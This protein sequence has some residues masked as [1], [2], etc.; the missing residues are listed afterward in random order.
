MFDSNITILFS[1]FDSDTAIP[2]MLTLCQHVI[3]NPSSQKTQ[4]QFILS[5]R[6][7]LEGIHD[8]QDVLSSGIDVPQEDEKESGEED[9]DVFVS[10]SSSLTPAQERM[11]KRNIER[12][13]NQPRY[14]GSL[15]AAAAKQRGDPNASRTTP[16]HP[17]T[18]DSRDY[19][20][21]VYD[22]I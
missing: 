3:S 1:M 10:K 19:G 20:T 12:L 14:I 2:Q 16:A 22:L 7:L 11:L 8:I 5:L 4:D 18:M 15:G 9:V 13:K 17:D 21:Q 6:E